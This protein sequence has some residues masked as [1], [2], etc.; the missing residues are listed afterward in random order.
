MEVLELR[1]L[2]TADELQIFVGPWIYPQETATARVRNGP[3]LC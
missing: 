1:G 3:K 2:R